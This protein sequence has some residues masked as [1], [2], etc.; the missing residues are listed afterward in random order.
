MCKVFFSRREKASMV[1]PEEREGRS[2][3]N[4]DLVRGSVSAGDP[5]DTR[6]A[7]EACPPVASKE[8]CEVPEFL[9]RDLVFSTLKD[10]VCSQ[11]LVSTLPF[12]NPVSFLNLRL[13]ACK[14]MGGS[15]CTPAWKLVKF[16][17]CFSMWLVETQCT[18]AKKFL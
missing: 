7:G 18:F 9:C 8:G 5:A 14:I 17:H 2:E 16:Q 12:I 4:L 15:C 1:V 6:K 13:L 10:D 11:T 3:S